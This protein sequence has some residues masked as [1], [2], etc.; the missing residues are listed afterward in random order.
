VQSNGDELRRAIEQLAIGPFIMTAAHESKRAGLMVTSVQ[1]CAEEPLLICV[2]SRKGHVIEPLIRDSR[3]FVVCRVPADDR[4]A[5]RKFGLF[6][7]VEERGDPFDS[8]DVC[9]L[10]GRAPVLRRSELAFECEVCRHF[11]LEADHEL[12]VGLVLAARVGPG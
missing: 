6:R 1:K 9:T 7:P 11:D 4:I 10:A 5:A 3:R 2:A 12:Y 8:L